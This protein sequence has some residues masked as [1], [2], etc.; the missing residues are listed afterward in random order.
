[1]APKQ[2][3][4][5]GP[6]SPTLALYDKVREQLESVA[7]DVIV[8]FD[9][10]HFVNFFFD[11]FPAFCVGIVD[12]AWGPDE[13]RLEMPKYTVPVHQAM[14]RALLEY[15]LASEF[16]VSSK[17]EM[18]LDHSILVPLHF[19]TPRMH[20]PIVPVYI[21]GLAKPLP[22]SRRCWAL[23]QMVG[24]FIRQAWPG[25]ERVAVLGSGS[26]SLE[27][28]GPR[29]GQTDFEW[30]RTL[31]DHL[32]NG[33]YQPIVHAATTERMLAA[34]NVSGELL[35]W[36]AMLGALDGQRPVFVEPQ[37]ERGHAF[38]VWCA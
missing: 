9:S 36:I 37:E 25:P 26:F 29:I 15:A 19:L 30:V 11:N 4:E 21:R 38:G 34:G 35:N 1:M 17:E 24:R 28:G 16:D 20:I 5:E 33:R 23:G 13:T 22:L 8:V 2:V 27:V 7:P 10:D 3:L 18:V 6:T 14:A 31:V 32:R 12:E